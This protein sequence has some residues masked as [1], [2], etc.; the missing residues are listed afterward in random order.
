M[1]LADVAC[2]ERLAGGRDQVPVPCAVTQ[3]AEQAAGPA[4]VLGMRERIDHRIGAAVDQVCE[5]CPHVFRCEFRAADADRLCSCTGVIRACARRAGFCSWDPAFPLDVPA[6]TQ[7]AFCG[8]AYNYVALGGRPEAAAP[9]AGRQV[10]SVAD[11][12]S[13][14]PRRH[15]CLHAGDH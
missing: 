9:A 14:T 7:V 15:N 6:A 3:D 2:G 5:R 11:R 10:A 12:R 4:L 13:G 1:H 8:L